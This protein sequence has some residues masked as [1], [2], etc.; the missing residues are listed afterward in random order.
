MNDFWLNK[1]RRSSVQ[2]AVD[3]IKLS[4]S[5]EISNLD[6]IECANLNYQQMQKYLDW[7][8]KANML[9]VVNPENTRYRYRSTPKGRLLLFTFDE[10]QKMLAS[11]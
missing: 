10:I 1:G 11:K 8:V 5:G 9:E 4:C 6:L 3:I 2:I 7:L